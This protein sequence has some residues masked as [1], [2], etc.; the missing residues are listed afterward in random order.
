MDK[1]FSPGIY[2][3]IVIVLTV[4]NVTL[5]SATFMYF[6]FMQYVSPIYRSYVYDAGMS[7]YMKN[8]V[9]VCIQISFFVIKE[10]FE[11]DKEICSQ[12]ILDYMI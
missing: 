3:K 9:G 1:I 2:R 11:K 12:K 7:V 6:I 8:I 10:S 4:V 5:L